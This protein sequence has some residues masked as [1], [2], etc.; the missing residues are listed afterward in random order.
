M[1]NDIVKVKTENYI[2]DGYKQKEAE[3]KAK[4]SVRSSMT[5]YWKPIF[6]EAYNSKD[7]AEQKRIRQILIASGLYGRT[8]EVIDTTQQWIK[9]SK[10]K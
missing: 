7:S 6:L 2:N 9:D 8:S 3:S 4:S 1:I 5:S 10:K